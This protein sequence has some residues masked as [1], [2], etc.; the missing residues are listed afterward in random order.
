[1]LQVS[2]ARLAALLPGA[3]VFQAQARKRAEFS[4][5]VSAVS[6]VTTSLREFDALVR[7]RQSPMLR[8]ILGVAPDKSTEAHGSAGAAVKARGGHHDGG[9]IP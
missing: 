5:F 4:V 9:A 2:A 7:M 1:M 3:V 8:Q 6:N